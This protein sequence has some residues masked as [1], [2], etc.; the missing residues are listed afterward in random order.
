L[1]ISTGPVTQEHEDEDGRGFVQV[2]STSAYRVG[3]IAITWMMASMDMG[4]MAATGLASQ[5]KRA[6][7][8]HSDLQERKFLRN[9]KIFVVQDDLLVLAYSW[10]GILCLSCAGKGPFGIEEKPSMPTQPLKR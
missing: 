8:Q 6:R 10:S 5:G 4:M 9:P 7:P 2:Y 3:E 1:A